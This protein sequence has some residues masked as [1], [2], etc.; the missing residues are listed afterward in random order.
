MSLSIRIILLTICDS[1]VWIVTEFFLFEKQA[2]NGVLKVIG[3]YST[4]V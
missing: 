1:S 3:L 2:F 4:I